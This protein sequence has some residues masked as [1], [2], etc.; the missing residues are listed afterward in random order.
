MLQNI[1]RY[2][3]HSAIFVVFLWLQFNVYINCFNY[4]YIT[5]DFFKLITY[6]LLFLD[7]FYEELLFILIK[8]NKICHVRHRQTMYCYNFDTI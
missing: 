5:L 2:F 1:E 3:N 7:M 4:K 6:H 8:Q